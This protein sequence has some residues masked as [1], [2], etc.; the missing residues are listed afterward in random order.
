MECVSSDCLCGLAQVMPQNWNVVTYNI[1]L[2]GDKCGLENV[3][4]KHSLKAI[5]FCHGKRQTT[6]KN[7]LSELPGCQSFNRSQDT[8]LFPF[9]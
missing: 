2:Q 3:L 7:Q 5:V 9:P 6:F 8:A 1:V 4:S